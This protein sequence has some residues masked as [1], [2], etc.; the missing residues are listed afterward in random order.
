M[1]LSS[2]VEQYV[3]LGEEISEMQEIREGIKEQIMERVGSDTV[4]AGE[5]VVY[6]KERITETID[7][8]KVREVVPAEVL[9]D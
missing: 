7:T 9:Q 6:T 5:Y 3:E 1:E 2:L 8:K 4:I